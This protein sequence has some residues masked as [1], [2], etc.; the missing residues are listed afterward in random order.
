VVWLYITDGVRL[1]YLMWNIESDVICF[2]RSEQ[3]YQWL[4]VTFVYHFSNGKPWKMQQIS[5]RIQRYRYWQRLH[6]WYVSFSCISC[7]NVL[8]HGLSGLMVAVWESDVFWFAVQNTHRGWFNVLRL[9]QCTAGDVLQ[10]TEG[11]LPG[12]SQGT[13]GFYCH[14]WIMSVVCML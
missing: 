2:L 12:A 7:V 9:L 8:F 13:K 6:P 10:T 1:T 11:P 4:W 14:C 5:P 3:H